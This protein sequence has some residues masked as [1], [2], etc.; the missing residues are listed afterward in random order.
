MNPIGKLIYCDELQEEFLCF[1]HKYAAHLCNDC[2][3]K[4]ICITTAKNN[5]ELSPQTFTV[6]NEYVNGV[7]N[8]HGSYLPLRGNSFYRAWRHK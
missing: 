5:I 1:C 2:P 4:F 3:C 6:T 7:D 8:K